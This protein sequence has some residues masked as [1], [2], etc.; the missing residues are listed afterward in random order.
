MNICDRLSFS[1]DC[2]LCGVHCVMKVQD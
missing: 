1:S 2:F